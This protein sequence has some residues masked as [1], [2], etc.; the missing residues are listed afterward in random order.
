MR[1]PTQVGD[2]GIVHQADYY[3]GG[4]SGIGGGNSDFSPRGNLTPL[5]FKPISQNV[6]EGRDYDQ[7]T[8]YGGPHG[9]KIIQRPQPNSGM[10]GSGTPPTTPTP[11]PTASLIPYTTI[12]I[13][14]LGSM[15]VNAIS[16][17][18]H[19][20]D[21]L[22]SLD[23][24]PLSFSG[25]LHMA[26]GGITHIADAALGSI[27]PPQLKGILNLAQEAITH[28]SLLGTIT[29]ASL[30]GAINL[31]QKSL[32]IGA[33]SASYQY[34]ATTPPLPSLPTIVNLIG[35]LSATANIFA[36]GSISAGNM[37]SGGQPVMTQ[38]VPPQLI[39]A[40]QIVTGSKQGNPA[41]TSLIHALVT[42]GLIIDNTT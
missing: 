12:N 20:A 39:N 35:S 24:L 30:T 5:V 11:T 33:P 2:K 7:L 18:T 1:E 17:I 19:I 22:I 8:L 40:P 36:A 16:G 25:I 38:P 29:H 27:I 3:L 13:N 6:F 26:E 15:A 10:G 42:L 31:V 21:N 4:I 9:V 23:K 32:T 37:S 28:T 14:Q 41:L 34:D